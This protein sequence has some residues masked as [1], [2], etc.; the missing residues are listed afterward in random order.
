MFECY[1]L[2]SKSVSINSYSPLD[3]PCLVAISLQLDTTSHNELSSFNPQ[4]D[5]MR[6]Y[7]LAV[8]STDGI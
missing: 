8:L 6:F 7:L 1:P 5:K 4:K 3:I 2:L